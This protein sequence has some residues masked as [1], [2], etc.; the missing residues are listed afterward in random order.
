MHEGSGREVM[1]LSMKSARAKKISSNHPYILRSSFWQQFFGE[2]HLGVEH[3]SSD[4]RIG[5]KMSDG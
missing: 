4:E 1:L 5:A 2:V 3:L